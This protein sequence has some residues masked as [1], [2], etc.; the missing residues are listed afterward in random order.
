MGRGVCEAVAVRDALAVSPARRGIGDFMGSKGRD[1]R[2][3]RK[4]SKSS[5]TGKKHDRRWA[6]VLVGSR[7]GGG[8][9]TVAWLRPCVMSV[10]E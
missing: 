4:Q 10:T 6:L 2:G 1:S 8:G 9:N 7:S 5:A 3:C